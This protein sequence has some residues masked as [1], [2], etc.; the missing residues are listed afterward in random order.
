MGFPPAL[1]REAVFVMIRGVALNSLMTGVPAEP[2]FAAHS[3]LGTLAWPQASED[4]MGTSGGVDDSLYLVE[5]AIFRCVKPKSEK[6]D[7]NQTS[8]W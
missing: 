5:P 6:T 1:V 2:I 8:L 3:E 4:P 7:L